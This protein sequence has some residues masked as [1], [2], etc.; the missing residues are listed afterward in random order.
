MLHKVKYMIKVAFAILPCNYI[1][2][3]RAKW[4]CTLKIEW[5]RKV[6]TTNFQLADENHYFL[7]WNAPK[8]LLSLFT[9]FLQIFDDE[10]FLLELDH[11]VKFHRSLLSNQQETRNSKFNSII[12]VDKKNIHSR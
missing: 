6:Y 8:H 2:K 3:I 7:A 11:E 10:N 1:H 5:K 12:T 4:K 9:F